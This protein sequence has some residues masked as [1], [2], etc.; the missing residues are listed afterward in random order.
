[1]G[2]ATLLCGLGRPR[3]LLQGALYKRA[4]ETSN[5]HTSAGE[6]CDLSVFQD[7]DVPREVEKGRDVRRENVFAI[8]NA[9]Y[10]RRA[11]DPGSDQTVRKILIDDGDSARAVHLAERL[12][13]GCFQAAVEALLDEVREDFRVGVGNEVMSIGH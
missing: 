11:A 8:R 4:I 12:A 1:M 5:L 10:Q 9:D 6:R 7:E 2:V 3:H 13:H